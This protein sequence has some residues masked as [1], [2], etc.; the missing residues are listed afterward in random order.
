[1][2]KVVAA[3][4]LSGALGFLPALAQEKKDSPAKEGMPMK[5]DG[6]KGGGIM[7]EQLKGMQREHG[8]KC[9]KIW[10]E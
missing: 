1:M 5:G 4:V 3:M 10:A 8:A 2:K 6:M 9:A 7:M